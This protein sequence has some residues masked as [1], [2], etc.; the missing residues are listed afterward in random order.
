MKRKKTAGQLEAQARAD[1]TKYR[2]DEIAEAACADI[3]DHVMECAK[4]HHNIIDEDEFFVVMLLGSDPILV[5]VTRRKF[6]A[7]PFL[8]EP[9]PQ[10]SVWHYRKS[11]QELQLLWALPDAD[12]MAMLSNMIA[13]APQYRNMKLWSDWFFSG[14]FPAWV[15]KHHHQP[16]WLTEKEFLSVNSAELTNASMDSSDALRSKA[17]EV[18]E[19]NGVEV[20]NAINSVRSEDVLSCAGEAKNAKGCIIS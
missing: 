12:A 4:K 5:T 3:G 6:Y 2:A 16:E 19:V 15:R 13:P 1:Q 18:P 14:T 8:P 17:P 9:R 7:W 10:Q 20:A 11:T